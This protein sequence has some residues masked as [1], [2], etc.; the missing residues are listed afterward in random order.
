MEGFQGDGSDARGK[1]SMK[2]LFGRRNITKSGLEGKVTAK[3][4]YG[5]LHQYGVHTESA[6][7]FY[8][9]DPPET[10]NRPSF[11]TAGVVMCIV[12]CEELKEE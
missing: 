9:P 8:E 4:Q 3:P 12:T 2:E 1:I 11:N 10:V 7:C 6:V 5:N